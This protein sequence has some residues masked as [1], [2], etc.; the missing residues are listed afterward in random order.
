MALCL[1]GAAS[2]PCGVD[3]LRP[4]YRV[5]GN[6]LIFSILRFFLPPV[7]EGPGRRAHEAFSGF[8]V[9]RLA[10]GHVPQRA[11][12][13]AD[14][15]RRPDLACRVAC[16][17]HRVDPPRPMRALALRQKAAGRSVSGGSLGGG[18]AH[19]HQKRWSKPENRYLIFDKSANSKV[20]ASLP[21]P[22]P[23]IPGG[24]SK[25]PEKYSLF[26]KRLGENHSAREIFPR[27][28]AC[29]KT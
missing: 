8:R 13:L 18:D 27:M 6:V 5:L 1:S 14:C 9:S 16:D 22:V 23:G 12:R 29:G 15:S 28:A 25:N 17:R 7:R 11:R 2:L 10:L 20:G 4:G 19:W 24:Q 21:W 3:G 26:A